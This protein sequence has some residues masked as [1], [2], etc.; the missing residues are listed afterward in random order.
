MADGASSL[1]GLLAG[2]SPLAPEEVQGTIAGTLGMDPSR[3]GSSDQFN[4]MGQVFG[5][6]AAG[7]QRAQAINAAQ[8]IAAA[9]QDALPALARA[10]ASDDPY[11]AIANDPNATPYAKWMLLNQTPEEMARNKYWF[12]QGQLLQPDIAA[13]RA[14]LPL[15][16]KGI[17]GA[18]SSG[19][20]AAPTSTGAP[21]P[22][23]P[24]PA[25]SATASLPQFPGRLTPTAGPGMPA[26]APGSP[27][28]STA[29][30][31]P[32][33][34]QE[35]LVGQL[36]PDRAGAETYWRG[37]NAPQRVALRQQLQQRMQQMRQTV[38]PAG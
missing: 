30:G 22:A 27:G 16:L 34:A 25:G 29:P 7:Q 4:P 15:V 23:A 38:Q 14:G 20:G 12:G 10:Y 37:L 21:A 35:D 8:Q 6:L 13:K 11:S 28:A 33:P 24:V 19:T 3:L 9:H 18:Q 31:T 26:A 36:P 1:I 5:Q 32:A 17:A 2:G